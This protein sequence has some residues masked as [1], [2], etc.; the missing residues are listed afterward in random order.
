MT[1]NI[2]QTIQEALTSRILVVDG[3]MGTSIQSLDLTADDFGG[4]D[5]EGCNEY[6]SLTNPNAI[7]LIHEDY[8]KAGA[9]I[10]ETNT[11]GA[12]SVVLAEYELQ[13]LTKEL[14]LTSA[15]L[16]RE[17]AD[18]YS[19]DQHPRYVAGSM[20]PTTKTISLTGGISFEELV[21][22]YKE[23]AYGLLKGNVDF[24]LLETCQ[25]TINIKAGIDGINQ[26]I[27]ASGISVPIAIQGTIEPMG[28]LLAGQDIEALYT[29][30]QHL[31][32][33]WIGLN[34]ATG[35]SFMSD[36]IRQLAEFSKFPIACIPNAGLPDEDGNYNETPDMF[37][38]TV[39]G[40][41]DNG[42][43]NIVGGCCGTRPDHIAKLSAAIEHV[44]PRE[45][46]FKTETRVSGIEALLIDDD[47]KPII[48]GERTNVLGSRRFKRLIAQEALEEASEIG[49][50]Q[51]RNG[52]HIL[53]V[54]L[55]DP[56]RDELS[57]IKSYLNL[58]TKKTKAPIMID[59]TDSIVIRESL[60]MLQGK[61]IINSINLEDGESRF[62]EIVPLIHQYG[63]SVVV[64]CID[65]DKDQAQAITAERKLQVA[66]RSFNL[67]T[68]KY[69]LEESDIIFDPLVFPA[70]TGDINYK[71]SA[72]E[73][74]EGVRAIK[75]TFP[76]CKTILGISNVSFGLPPAGREVFNS[77]F[78]YHCIQ[79]GLDMAIVNSEAIVR[80]NT[81]PDSE[82]T[83][84]ENLIW[85]KGDDPITEFTN[86]FRDIKPK[87]TTETRSQMT[88]QERLSLAII[89]GTKEGITQ[90]LD[91]GLETLVPLE[92]INGP[93]MK[94]MEEV[95]RQFN[96]NELIVAEVLQ[97]AE[98]MKHAVSYLEQFMEKT[99]IVNK[100]TVLLATVKGDVH[101]IGKNLVDIILSNNGFKVIN[102][103]I[104]IAPPELIEAYR[105]HKPDFIGLSGLLVKSAQMMVAT[106]QDLTLAEI[107]CPI[108]VGG[109]A[110]S[111]R[112]TRLRIGPEYSGPVVY[113]KDAMEGLTYSNRLIEPDQLRQ[114][115]D[116]LEEETEALKSQD[117]Q[118]QTTNASNESP[119]EAAQI[120][121]D[122]DAP[123]PPDLMIHQLTNYSLEDIW[124]YINPQML[125]VRHLGYRGRWEEA[126]QEN[127]PT[128]IS[129]QK[130][131][132]HVKNEIL[133][134]DLL[135][136]SALFKFFPCNSQGEVINIK[137]STGTEVIQTLSFGRQSDR[138]GLCISDYIRP[139]STNQ[140]DYI[141]MFVTSIGSN[142]IQ[143]SEDWKSQGRLLDSHILQVLALET[144]EGF[145][146]LLH[147]NM[148]AMW[149]FSDPRSTSFTDLHR[150]N[151]RGKRYSFGYPACPRLE[152]QRILFDLLEA[153]KHLN[154]QLTEEYM[155]DPEA[156]V[157]ALV[158]HHPDA[159]YFNLSQRDIEKLG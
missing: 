11:F 15:K 8:L 19:T 31:D 151:Y 137:N 40:F 138:D 87:S 149:G 44:S 152:D 101:D 23:Q 14:N 38:T 134:N 106:A 147:Q 139:E 61:S 80:Y 36:H 42:W 132:E 63:A 118:S 32:L 46:I 21:E 69:L 95:G 16:A 131:V 148:R 33:L 29:S 65:D 12:T 9:D 17:M 129:L 92:I 123:T 62:A 71:G 115:T 48:V 67:L 155:M 124:P 111:N 135:T 72:A 18:K 34:C 13:H 104:K 43:I 107:N 53:D 133:S 109:A 156:S 79:A 85:D 75:E 113:C 28:T 4:P 70:A 105:E 45:P 136:A 89:E 98:A 60:K 2:K 94:G 84:A 130:S 58:L 68:K 51:I 56:D 57:D 41:A 66:E 97:S 26:A 24:L 6:L 108:L 91:S 145:A 93:L 7:S 86:H 116:E 88:W 112:F 128:A 99:E 150:A 102:L 20:G 110:L 52:A 125:Y 96:A 76:N 1:N 159:K 126:I 83:L 22:S 140:L 54:C 81:I 74:I 143:I 25:D 73:T 157:S 37:S 103:G 153:E 39:K 64:G 27:E 78:M 144:A 30:L 77:V 55:Q 141:G 146:E 90:D 120:L 100:G 121:H 114:L 5:Y 127:E 142:V 59:S 119:V 158:M 122:F 154:I 47:S 49:R 82:K 3:A 10:I 50:R 35:P 117:A